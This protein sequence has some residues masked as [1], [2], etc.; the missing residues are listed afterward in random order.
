LAVV[1]ISCPCALGLAT[2][3]A[4]WAAIG[5]AAQRQVLFRHGD[6]LARLAQAKVICFDKTGTLTTGQLVVEQHWSN[7][8]A[9]M[10]VAYHLATKSNHPAAKALLE[11]TRAAAQQ[12]SLSNFREFPGRG[13][14]ATSTALGCDVFLGN[15]RWLM[16]QG[17]NESTWTQTNA[18]REWQDRSLVFLAWAG[19]VR[20]VFALQEHLRAETADTIAALKKLGLK[21]HLLTGDRAGR[22]QV[23]ADSLGIQVAAELLP[24]QK[25][26]R[27]ARLRQQFGPVIMV[28]DGL[29][30]APALAAAD[31]GIALG[32]GADLSRDA[33]GVCLIG[34]QLD[35]IPWA[36]SLARDANRTIRWN[37]FW[38]FAYNIAGIP[39]A[40]LGL[41][42]PILAA[43]A[44]A[45]SSG[46]VTTNSLRL[47]G[48]T[49]VTAEAV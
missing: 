31:I 4:L 1:V 29:N 49:S 12:E 45:V 6:A 13:I 36:I 15:L 23:L 38:A 10:N 28:G 26:E 43:I 40:A 20:G 34:N 39:L 19:E 16:E 46:L 11:Y 8:P 22:A 35:R 5:R 2:P 27:V 41:V 30:D 37:L 25:L 18:C 14:Q 33:A 17:V 48:E 9:A 32:C 47:A 44:M 7:T 24:E 3:L 42:N 21:V